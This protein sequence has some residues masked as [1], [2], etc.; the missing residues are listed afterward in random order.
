MKT[1][2]LARALEEL[3][4]VLRASQ[5][6]PLSAAKMTEADEIADNPQ[7]LAGIAV[8]LSTLAELSRIR[9]QEWQVLIQHYKL[10][11]QVKT[12][13]SVRDLLGRLLKYLESN[14]AARARL[15]TEAVSGTPGGSPELD[16][17]LRFLLQPRP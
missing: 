1:H 16:R 2:D 10:P 12:T 3:A 9:K 8:N 7:K 14:D 6:M 15:R 5:N 4:E 17:A 13:D 11:V